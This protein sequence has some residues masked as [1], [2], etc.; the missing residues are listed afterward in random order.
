MDVCVPVKVGG[1]CLLK[2]IILLPMGVSIYA[3]LGMY[4]Y[5]CVQYASEKELLV[6]P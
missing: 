1:N 3:Y 2:C 5:E 4:A 6:C